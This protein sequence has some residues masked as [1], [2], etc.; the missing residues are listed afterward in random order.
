MENCRKISGYLNFLLDR[1]VL[2]VTL[3]G[4]LLAFHSKSMCVSTKYYFEVRNLIEKSKNSFGYQ[5]ISRKYGF[6]GN[7]TKT[8][9]TLTFLN[10]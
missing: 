10:L 1:I 4:N 2:T 7:Q 3:R 9:P 5:K 6:R 8:N